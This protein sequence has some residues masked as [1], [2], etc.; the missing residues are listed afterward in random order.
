MVSDL[1][2]HYLGLDQNKTVERRSG[3]PR[4]H[5]RDGAF[6]FDLDNERRFIY[7]PETYF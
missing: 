4:A 5:E 2:P 6:V 1:D 7:E 3:G